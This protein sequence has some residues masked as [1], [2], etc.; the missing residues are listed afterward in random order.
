ADTKRLFQARFTGG[1]G[2]EGELSQIEAQYQT[3]PAAVSSPEQQI[4]AQEN[5]ISLLLGRYSPTIPRG[6]A[7]DELVATAI[8]AGLPSELLER[9]PDIL[10][11]EQNLVSANANIGVAKS[12]YFPSISVTGL[13]G[14]VSTAT[15]DFLTGPSKAWTVAADLTGPIF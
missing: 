10:Q 11:A 15:S 9:R 13:L 1:G 6:Q 3:P 8:P 5:P 4:A 2:S 7:I 12:L 14:S